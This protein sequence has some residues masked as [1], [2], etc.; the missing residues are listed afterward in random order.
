MESLAQDSCCNQ[1]IWL[2]TKMLPNLQKFCLKRNSQASTSQKSTGIQSHYRAM[3]ISKSF[4]NTSTSGEAA[5]KNMQ[6][7]GSARD[8]ELAFLDA[9]KRHGMNCANAIRLQ[10]IR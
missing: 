1:M 4:A 6:T 5:I 3:K 7:G 10:L 8:Y 2:D 9:Q